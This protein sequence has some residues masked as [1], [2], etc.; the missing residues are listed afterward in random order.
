MTKLWIKFKDLNPTQVSTKDCSNIDDLLEACKE[1]LSNQ[2]KE[3]DVAELS[4]SASDH[5]FEPDDPIP[6]QN[7]SKTAFRITTLKDNGIC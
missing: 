7:T 2:L 3:Y 6:E 1:K 5:T 4:L